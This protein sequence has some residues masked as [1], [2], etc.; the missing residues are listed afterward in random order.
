MTNQQKQMSTT[1]QSALKKSDSISPSTKKQAKIV[2]FHEEL[3]S[4]INDEDEHN[5]STNQFKPLKLFG[6]DPQMKEQPEIPKKVRSPVKNRGA[7]PLK[8]QPT[9]LRQIEE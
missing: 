3:E 1:F 8:K 4:F 2:R 9:D 7:S 6:T 5:E